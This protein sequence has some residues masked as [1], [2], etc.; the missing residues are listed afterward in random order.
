MKAHGE[1]GV[2]GVRAYFSAAT[3]RLVTLTRALGLLVLVRTFVKLAWGFGLGEDLNSPEFR[4]RGQF[5]TGQP[6]C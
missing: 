4:L 1:T 2:G 5:T 6:S 3:L